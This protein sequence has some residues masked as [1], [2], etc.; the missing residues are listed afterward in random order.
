[1]SNNTCT[2]TVNPAPSTVSGENVT[3]TYGEDIVV[4]VTSVNAT[5][6]NYQILLNGSVVANGTLAVGENITG[7]V[8]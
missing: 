6:V 3:V 5:A 4:P 1:M 2:I 8:I 7:L